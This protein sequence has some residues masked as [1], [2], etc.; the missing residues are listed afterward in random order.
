MIEQLKRTSS[1]TNLYIDDCSYSGTQI[2]AYLQK[3]LFGIYFDGKVQE[4]F[5]TEGVI[6]F[7]LVIPFMKPNIAQD[8][9][10]LIDHY[11]TNELQG[12]VINC[13]LIT[14][15]IICRIK[16]LPIDENDKQTFLE[17]THSF[18]EKALT[19]TDWKMPDFVSFPH[20]FMSGTPYVRGAS[21]QKK[22]IPF[23][24]E[25]IDCKPYK[26]AHR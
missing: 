25:D 21:E 16:D 1:T 26:R 6:N 3:I 2:C 24:P 12:I 10:S 15:G 18:E 17:A 8:I 22:P 9:K 4:D 20:F 14:S 5:P 7:I 13:K 23:L 19:L 11:A